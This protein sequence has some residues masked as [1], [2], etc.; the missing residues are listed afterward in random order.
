MPL[1]SEDSP[2]ELTHEE[3]M[4]TEQQKFAKEDTW[5]PWLSLPFPLTATE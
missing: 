2:E 1:Q 4:N 3:A 5:Q